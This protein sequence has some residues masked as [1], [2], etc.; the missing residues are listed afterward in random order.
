M[1]ANDRGFLTAH[2]TEGKINEQAEGLGS[3]GKSAQ[4]VGRCYR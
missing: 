3:V 2:T 4:Y 1:L